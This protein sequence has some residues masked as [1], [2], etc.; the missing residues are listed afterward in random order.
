MNE[1][2]KKKNGANFYKV[3]LHLHTPAG[4]QSTIPQLKWK[5]KDYL[6]GEKRHLTSAK[7]NTDFRR[8]H[9]H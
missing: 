9:A 4:F 5:W 7:K 3:D 1:I 6:K 8:N 2:L